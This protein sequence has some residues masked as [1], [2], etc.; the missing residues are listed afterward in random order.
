MW[1][2]VCPGPPLFAEAGIH[3]CCFPFDYPVVFHGF[4]FL[5]A[6]IHAAWLLPAAILPPRWIPSK[7]TQN[8]TGR[9]GA[10][11]RIMQYRFIQLL[12]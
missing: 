3:T 11:V 2:A 9:F 10:P 12:I 5:E 4:L 7:Q 1:G 6:T 8:K